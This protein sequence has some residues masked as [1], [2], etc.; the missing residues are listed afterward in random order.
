MNPYKIAAI[1][2]IAVGG[3]FGTTWWV[4]RRIIRKAK[5]SFI[6]RIWDKRPQWIRIMDNI[7]GMWPQEQK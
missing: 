2:G 6:S 1:V 3:L 5:E 4:R 7:E